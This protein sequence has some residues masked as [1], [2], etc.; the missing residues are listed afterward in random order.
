MENEPRT[1]IF[2]DGMN[3]KARHEKA[4]E[5]VRGSIYFKVAPFITFLERNKDERGYVNV[6]M[7]KSKKDGS[8]Y[9]ILDTWKPEKKNIDSETGEEIPDIESIATPQNSLSSKDGIELEKIPF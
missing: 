6:K 8:I 9:F 3:F 7:M 2:A 1:M 5:T 4:P